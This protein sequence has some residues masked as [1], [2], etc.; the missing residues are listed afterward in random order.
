VRVSPASRLTRATLA[1]GR[2]VIS[3]CI[4]GALVSVLVLDAAA[5]QYKKVLVQEERPFTERL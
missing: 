1:A 4:S 3:I 2:S 5:L